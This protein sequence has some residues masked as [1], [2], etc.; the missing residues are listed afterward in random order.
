[1]GGTAKLAA[2]HVCYPSTSVGDKIKLALE[3][4]MKTILVLSILLSLTVLPALCQ[5]PQTDTVET[6]I[7]VI[8]TEI[9]VIKKEDFMTS[10]YK[11]QFPF[12]TQKEIFDWEARYLKDQSEKRQDQEQTVITLKEKVETRKTPETPQGYLSQPELRQMA[13]WKDRF[14]PNKIDKNSPGLIEKITSEAFGLDDDWE[15]I[16]KLKEIYGVAASVASV[17]LHL[18]DEGNYPILDVHALR[19]IG[20]DNKKVNYDEPFWRKY[21]NLCRAKAKR[22]NVS[23]RTLDRALYKYSERDAVFV[24]TVIADETLFLELQRRGYDLSRLREDAEIQSPA[25]KIV[26]EPNNDLKK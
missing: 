9:A 8:K 15:K 23:M 25:G 7:A 4:P 11:M 24:M 10:Q 5:T 21:V 18:Y 12:T 20:I 17:I 26:S 2:R 22:Y 3:H 1:M 19:T 16:K 6:D 13:K 14:V